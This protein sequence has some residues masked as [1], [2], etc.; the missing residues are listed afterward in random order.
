MGLSTAVMSAQRPSI[1]SLDLPLVMDL[2]TSLEAFYE[3]ERDAQLKAYDAGKSGEWK[4]L[5]P[6]IGVGYTVSNEPRP[7]IS[8]SPI[9]ILNRK[10]AK[11]Q[12]ALNR[13]AIVLG[14]E[15]VIT[16]HLYKLRQL[17]SDYFIDLDQLKSKEEALQIDELLYDIVEERYAE[18]LIEPI[19]YLQEQKKILMARS[20][21]DTYRHELY[22]KRSEV[23][24]VAKWNE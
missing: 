3:G 15:L 17:V 13:E 8:W 10:D 4:D 21:V 14:Y 11:R 1:P 18:N 19:V 2:E 20:S 24:Y 6:S 23:I 12:Q 22:K 5:L 9:S 7:T 16:D